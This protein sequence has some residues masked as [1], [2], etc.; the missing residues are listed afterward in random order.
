M[1]LTKDE[2]KVINGQIR[3]YQNMIKFLKEQIKRLKIQKEE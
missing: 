2:T 1:A 3:A